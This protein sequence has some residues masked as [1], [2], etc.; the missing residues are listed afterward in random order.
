MK[1]IVIALCSALS[2]SVMAATPDCQS[3]PMSMA[4]VWMK[5]A[6]IVDI[7]KLDESKTEVKRLASEK[8]GKDLYTQV[9]HFVFHDKSGG[10]YEVITQSDA[11]S[12]ECSVS[13]VNS[14]LVSKSDVNH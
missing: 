1:R 10:R 9:Y 4:E 13:A 5:N 14:F 11:S 7:V 12:S 2:C 3:W 6:G 8:K